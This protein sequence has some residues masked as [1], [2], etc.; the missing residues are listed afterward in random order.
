MTDSALECG[1]LPS[2]EN[3]QWSSEDRKLFEFLLLLLFNVMHAKHLVKLG[4]ACTPPVPLQKGDEKNQS[5]K[6]RFWL[7]LVLYKFPEVY[8]VVSSEDNSSEQILTSIFTECGIDSNKHKEEV[9]A[10]VS[11][12]PFFFFVRV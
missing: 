3:G 6:L 4:G 9:I 5:H 12:K 10:G 2:N 1:F 11:N 8:A 7:S